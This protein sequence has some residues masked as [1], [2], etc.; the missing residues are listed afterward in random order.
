MLNFGIVGLGRIGKVHLSNIQRHC[1]NAKVIAAGPVKSKDKVFLNENGVEF[2][3]DD[4]DQMIKESKLD[5]IIIASPTSFHYEH[6][7]LAAKA[8]IHIFSG[9]FQ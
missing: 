9:L 6:I 1:T 3:F 8:G 5:A 7:L 2:H 4:Y